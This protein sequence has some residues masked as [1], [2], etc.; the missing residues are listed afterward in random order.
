MAV[1]RFF[2]RS[3]A[4]ELGDGCGDFGA[5][6]QVHAV[7]EAVCDIQA[8]MLRVVMGF[9]ITQRSGTVRDRQQPP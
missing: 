1:F 3:L 4:E 6:D 5:G 9:T 8:D 7:R 2:N